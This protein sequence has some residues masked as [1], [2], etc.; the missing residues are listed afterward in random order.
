MTLVK[1]AI[2]FSMD[3]KRDIILFYS[4][5][6]KRDFSFVPQIPMDFCNGHTR[7]FVILWYLPLC[8]FIMWLYSHLLHWH[9][10]G[11]TPHIHTGA[12]L[13]ASPE[14]STSDDHT[15]AILGQI[16]PPCHTNLCLLYSICGRH[17]NRGIRG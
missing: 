7:K 6:R 14:F 2:K 13:A 5:L 1:L 8:Q 10:Y 9:S 4:H 12:V 16:P 17:W 11:Y 3:L 15:K